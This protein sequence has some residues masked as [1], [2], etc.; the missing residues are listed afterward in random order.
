[1]NGPR[2]LLEQPGPSA[3]LLRAAD[4][5]VPSERARRRA[6]VTAGSAAATLAAS[7][8]S[9]AVGGG[10]LFK[11]ALIWLSAGVLGGVVIAGV[12]TSGVPYRAPLERQST[13]ADV[14]RAQGPKE[15][16]PLPVAS[17]PAIEPM[18]PAATDPNL[19]Q[20]P[21]N[22]QSALGSAARAVPI[23]NTS[24]AT[25]GAST[26]RRFAAASPRSPSLYDELRL[27]DGARAAA[28]GRDPRAVLALLDRYEHDYPYGQFVPESLALRIETVAR[29]GDL[30]QARALAARF[31]RDYPQHPLVGRVSA[32]LGD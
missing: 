27:I 6:L 22:V 29:A 13:A 16:T 18:E 14:P 23:P 20:A 25:A 12:A 3:R 17:S 9:A 11:S 24:P 8:S 26:P 32:A 30:T 10:A 5:H 4:T 19:A 2:R 1:M 15:S 28:V 7:G 21:A 31:R